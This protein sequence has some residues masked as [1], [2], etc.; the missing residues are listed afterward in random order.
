MASGDV[1]LGFQWQDS[2]GLTWEVRFY[3]H[4]VGFSGFAASDHESGTGT[5]HIQ[6]HDTRARKQS[7]A[8]LNDVRVDSNIENR[9]LGSMLVGEAI[10]ECIR[11]G[12]KGACGYLSEVDIGHFSKLKYFYEKLGFSVAFYDPSRPGYKYDRAGRI[13]M[14]F[15]NVQAEP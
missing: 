11:R 14:T 5:I 6:T 15:N 10:E 13:E 7:M 8:Y 12:H 9:G 2:N 4:P 3:N 1:F